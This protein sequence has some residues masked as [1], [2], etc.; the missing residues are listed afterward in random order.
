MT[1]RASGAV[2]AGL[3]AADHLQALPPQSPW[4]LFWRQFRRSQLAVAG[5]AL[6]AIFYAIALLAPF[7]APY[8]QESMD[9][10][11]FFH[12][13]HRLH[14]IDA[15]G[16]FHLAPFIHP[17][18]LVDPANL[19]FEEDAAI[20]CPDALRKLDGGAEAAQG[21]LALAALQ[22][23]HGVTGRGPEAEEQ[24]GEPRPIGRQLGD[25]MD[26]RAQIEPAG[27]PAVAQAP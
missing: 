9:R 25:L 10:Q 20:R 6:L 13:P 7:I 18:R 23:P 5:G 16:R 12:P 4:R 1:D 8:P 26:R 22:Q 3:E 17:T 15:A 21:I 11:R 24:E 19:G 27:D 14:W 2:A